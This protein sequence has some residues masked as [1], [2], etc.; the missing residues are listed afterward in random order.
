MALDL[1]AGN[2]LSASGF[3]DAALRNLIAG[4]VC[5]IVSLAFSLS[6][7]ALIFSGPLDPLSG[8]WHRGHF[9]HRDDRRGRH[10]VAQF[11]SIRARQP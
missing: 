1:A 9:H 7:A 3:F 4:A 6:Y 11:A 5:A 2:R 10:G 8:L